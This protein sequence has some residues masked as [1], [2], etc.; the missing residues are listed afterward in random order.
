MRRCLFNTISKIYET[1][2]LT[3]GVTYAVLTLLCS[4]HVREPLQ[5]CISKKE[6]EGDTPG[7][8]HK[9]V[10]V[11]CHNGVRS[12]TTVSKPLSSCKVKV[13]KKILRC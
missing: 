11:E 1:R 8:R 3:H 13:R 4:I 10:L 9:G 12:G 5:S 7:N 2:R 6:K